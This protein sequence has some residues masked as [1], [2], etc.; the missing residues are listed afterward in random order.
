MRAEPRRSPEDHRRPLRLRAKAYRKPRQVSWLETAHPCSYASNHAQIQRNGRFHRGL[1]ILVAASL[2]ALQAC[3][4]PSTPANPSLRSPLPSGD[5]LDS[6]RVPSTETTVSTTA[7]DAGSFIEQTEDGAIWWFNEAVG[8]RIA[9]GTASSFS[10][11]W[12]RTFDDDLQ[13]VTEADLVALDGTIHTWNHGEFERSP[14]ADAL[15]VP[16]D[17]MHQGP[18]ALWLEGAGRLMRYTLDGDIQEVSTPD[19][20]LQTWLPGP[21]GVIWMAAPTLVAVDTLAD[22]PVT[23]ES[24]TEAPVVDLAM[25]ATGTLWVLLDDND[26]RSRNLNGDW[27][28]WDTAGSVTTVMGHQ[29]AHGIWLNTDAGA[30]FVEHGL[31]HPIDVPDGEWL[32]VDPSGRLLVKTQA[33][34][35]RVSPHGTAVIAGLRPGQELRDAR[36]VHVFP[37]HPDDSLRVWLDQEQVMLEDDQVFIDPTTLST[38]EHALRVVW[39]DGDRARI[40]QTPFINGELPDATWDDDIVPI[41]Q[42]H[43]ESCHVLQPS[44]DLK[45]DTPD[46]WKKLIDVIIEQVSEQAP[47]QAPRMPPAPSA[48]LTTEQVLKIR[49]WKNGGFL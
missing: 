8:E 1:G 24:L 38:G 23:V 31:A 19:M 9:L 3:E 33:S 37:A 6:H 21:D 11:T 25:D 49:G 47:G 22:P 45:L 20:N 5:V 15:P 34:V 16:V 7:L 30:L 43:C 18:Y 2:V 12:T 17:L 39:D 4:A 40:T 10:A 46:K 35:E 27:A 48:P 32:E 41:F 28:K 44:N 36:A 13:T 14:L 42:A 29:A 26:L